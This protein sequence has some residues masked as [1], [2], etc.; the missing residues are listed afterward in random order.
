M[1]MVV[2]N[3]GESEHL[4]GDKDMGKLSENKKEVLSQ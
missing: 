1:I 2:S 4:T 3:H